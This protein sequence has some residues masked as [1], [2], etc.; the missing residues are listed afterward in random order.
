MSKLS[1]FETRWIDLIFENRNKEYGAYQLRQENPKTTMKALLI[2]TVFLAVVVAIPKFS[3]TNA[4]PV[5]PEI[6]LPEATL[7]KEIVYLKKTEQPKK[8]KTTTVAAV[9]KS[10]PKRQDQLVNPVVTEAQKAQPDIA[11]NETITNTP[12]NPGENP[13]APQGNPNGNSGGGGITTTETGPDVPFTSPELDV[14]PSFPG[15]V[16]AFLSYVGKNFRTPEVE[17]DRTMKIFVSFVVEIDGSLTD[18]KVIKD[19][20]YGLGAEAIRVLKS[21][22]TK[23][24]PGRK[25]GKAVRAYYNLPITVQTQ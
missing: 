9:K 15:G 2:T 6:T 22:R 20:G 4:A 16:N 17:L 19:P 14:N 13:G 8:L 5:T 18:I 23:W 1:I 11:I 3:K 24:Q 10:N 25:N 12:N 7:V 21:L